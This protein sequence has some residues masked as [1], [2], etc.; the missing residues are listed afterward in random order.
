LGTA[1]GS[2]ECGLLSVNIPL[3]FSVRDARLVQSPSLE[4]ELE[5]GLE[6]ELEAET[7]S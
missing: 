1:L 3:V 4:L 5:L 2:W 6:L 7:W